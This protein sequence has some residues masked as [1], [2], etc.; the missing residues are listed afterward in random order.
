MVIFR[1]IVTKGR[2][3][4]SVG[5]GLFLRVTGNAE[6]EQTF[7][8]LLLVV[9]GLIYGLVV[10]ATEVFEEGYLDPIIKVGY[11]YT[12]FS[13]VCILHVYF[14]PQGIKYRHSVYMSIDILVTSIVMHVFGKYGAPFFV[15]YLWMTVGNGFRYGYREL[16]LCAGLSLCC[17]LVVC[18]NTPYWMR[19]YYLAMTGVMLLSIIPLY[20]A[21]MLNRLQNEKERAE[22]AN[23][24]KSRFLANVS[25]EIR[26][27]LNA[28]M[29]FSSLL[30]KVVEKPERDRIVAHINDASKSLMSLVGGV[31]DFS[32]IEAG[33]VQL[34]REKFDLYHLV[35]SVASMLSIQAEEKG[36]RFVTD[37][38]VSVPPFVQGD[39]GRLRQVLVN[40]LGNAI[41]FT[42][43]GEVRLKVSKQCSGLSACRVLFEVSDTGIGISTDMQSR[44]FDRFRQADDSVQRK[45]GGTG[46]GTAIAKR[47]VELMGGNIGVESEEFQGSRF[48]FDIPLSAM[49]TATPDKGSVKIRI[50]DYFIVT[51]ACDTTLGEN[52][53][54]G[55]QAAVEG[56][57]ESYS[58]WSSFKAMKRNMAGRCLLV[59]CQ[60][61]HAAEVDALVREEGGKPGACL[62]AYHPEIHLQDKYLRSGFHVVV[63]SFEHINNALHYGACIKQAGRATQ[64]AAEDQ[65]NLLAQHG[66]LRVLV[67]DD[68]RMNRYV[69][70]DMLN[71]LGIA[72]DIAASGNAA[73][74]QLQ[75]NEYDII[76]LDI[77]MPGLSGFDVIKQYRKLHPA[78]ESVP[79]VVITGDATQEVYDE[80]A[81]LGVSRFLLKP[82]DHSKLLH[83][84]ASLVPVPG[85]AH[86][87]QPV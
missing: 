14:Y 42:N 23:R 31:L 27:P 84:I 70:K 7:M 17:F 37:L 44:I 36:V 26:T 77:Q 12:A 6:L 47:L 3:A 81:E 18:I 11:F 67:A 72:P 43:V 49:S 1:D 69:M 71:Q 53:V 78:A 13:I 8:R 82:V 35:Y 28:V 32:R 64:K 33:H 2:V 59:D 87:A 38:D 46:L 51:G 48:W 22:A 61:L 63:S 80:C 20:V 56:A 83:A 15:F 58:D 79:I 57:V 41:K 76:M 19:E 24:E 39:A 55:M 54:P 75:T 4:M 45:Y 74:E 16:I 85:R 66:D 9:S 86:T 21:L 5:N 62:I 34:K 65:A 40:L 73:L 29:G 68:C 52:V 10:S 60:G 30:G 25:H 50:P